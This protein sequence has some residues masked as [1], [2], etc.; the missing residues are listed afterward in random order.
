MIILKLNKLIKIINGNY[1][2]ISRSE[3]EHFGISSS[4]VDGKKVVTLDNFYFITSANKGLEID[5]DTTISL[6]GESKI[7]VTHDS[8]IGITGTGNVTL[9]GETIHIYANQ[10]IDRQPT[11][12]MGAN[13]FISILK[14]DGQ[15]INPSNL[16]DITKCTYIKIE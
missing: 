16:S 12:I 10:V 8:G 5:G 9:T 7:N 14:E 13:M 11:T 1:R 15:Y 6:V 3:L 4:E 2:G